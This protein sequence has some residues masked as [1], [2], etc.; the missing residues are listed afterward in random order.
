MEILT[1]DSTKNKKFLR[2][3]IAEFD[4]S[5]FG[6][7]EIKRLIEDMKKKMKTA[8]GIGLAANQVGIDA[9]VFVAQ[10]PDEKGGMKFYA[11]FNPKI[12]KTSSIKETLEE[13]CLSVP[14]TYGEVERSEKIT[15]TGYDQ[16][17]RK[18][19]IKAWGLLARV[20]QHEVDHLNGILFIDKAKNIHKATSDMRHETS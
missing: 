12:E 4:F 18:I 2:K 14:K 8:Q 19:K 6:R 10:I 1:I 11:I 5:K 20:F 17:G 7:K 13:G 16:N 15:L 9:K 3:K